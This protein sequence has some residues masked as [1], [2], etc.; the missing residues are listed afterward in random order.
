MRRLSG[1]LGALAL[2][3]GLGAV[4]FSQ[5]RM[6]QIVDQQQVI[7]DRQDRDAELD[8]AR[9]CVAAWEGRGELRDMAEVGYRRNADTLVALSAAS[10]N[11][12]RVA[13]YLQQ[14]ERDVDEIRST[15]PDPDCD[16]RAAQARVR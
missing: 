9:R 12:E 5:V 14:V 7:I 15:L 13:A 1:I 10:A 11:P 4:G 2:L 6:Q 3:V 16:L 8:E